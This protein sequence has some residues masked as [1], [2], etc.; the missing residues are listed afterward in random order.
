VTGTEIVYKPNP[1]KL[2]LILAGLPPHRV[3]FI[4]DFVSAILDRL[5]NGTLAN[6]S[7]GEL[8]R[9]LKI[10]DEVDAI[11]RAFDV[12]ANEFWAKYGQ[13]VASLTENVAMQ[14]KEDHDE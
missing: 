3:K 9:D 7:W 11:I 6:Y 10:L 4:L 2:K 5:R 14:L 8:A 12:P 13:N 1:E